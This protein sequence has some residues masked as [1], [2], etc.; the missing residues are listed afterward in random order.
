MSVLQNDTDADGDPLSAALVAGPQNGTLT[1]NADGSFVYTPNCNYTGT[2]A[3]QYKL[4]DG[5]ADSNVA[6]VSINVVQFNNPPT[7]TSRTVNIAVGALYAFKVDDFGFGDPNDYPPDHL[8]GV[9][10]TTL[11]TL[12]NLALAGTPVKAGQLVAVADLAAGKARV[13]ANPDGSA[14]R[15]YLPGGR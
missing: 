5:T 8:A 6:T 4:N 10:I 9:E 14:P 7:G 11:P 1:F 3:F 15:V 2:D 12:G 13:H